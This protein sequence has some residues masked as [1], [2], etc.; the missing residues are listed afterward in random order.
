MDARMWVQQL[1]FRVGSLVFGL[2][3]RM[4]TFWQPVGP[5]DAAAH[6]N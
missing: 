1:H 3:Q 6:G 4:E 2:H 5:L